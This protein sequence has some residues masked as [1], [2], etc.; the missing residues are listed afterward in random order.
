MNH[1]VDPRLI[2]Y[3]KTDDGCLYLDYTARSYIENGIFL[4]LEIYN[5]SLSKY[6][7][8]LKAW[9]RIQE[10]LVEDGH[11]FGYATAPPGMPEKLIRMFGLEYTG[12][13]SNG[14]KIMRIRLCHQQ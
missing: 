7:F 6:K 2:P 12:L 1:N 13:V 14:Y 9:K 5:W 10:K 8:F 3:Y 11:E 4:H